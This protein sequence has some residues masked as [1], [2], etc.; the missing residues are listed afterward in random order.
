MKIGDRVL[1]NVLQELDGIIVIKTGRRE[2]CTP[3]AMSPIDLG[4]G[5]NHV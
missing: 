1:E 3:S 5:I 2:A 4:G